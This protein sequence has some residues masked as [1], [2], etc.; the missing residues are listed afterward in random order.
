[1][2]KTIITHAAS[3]KPT[4]K[5][6][7]DP[8]T[9]VTKMDLRGYLVHL[10][11]KAE[12]I[13][14]FP[15]HPARATN[16]RSYLWIRERGSEFASLASSG[17]SC[18]GHPIGMKTSKIYDCEF[19]DAGGAGN[20]EGYRA[21]T[22]ESQ[23]AQSLASHGLRSTIIDSPVRNSASVMGTTASRAGNLRTAESTTTRSR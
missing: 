21:L 4:V 19:I 3:W 12:K 10:E 17:L 1:M 6:L 13:T 2:D 14:S 9:N 15:L 11:N 8:E 7:P 22:V 16:A 18:I 20:A 5:T 23:V